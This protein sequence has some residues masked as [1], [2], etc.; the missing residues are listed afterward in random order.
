MVV[1]NSDQKRFIE[2]LGFDPEMDYDDHENHMKLYDAVEPLY[3][4]RGFDANYELNEVGAICES[5]LDIL[6]DG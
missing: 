5:I 3:I 1:F 2:R 6:A 4:K